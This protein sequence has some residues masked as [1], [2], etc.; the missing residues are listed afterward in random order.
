M[1]YGKVQPENAPKEPD[2]IFCISL[3]FIIDKKFNRFNKL[4]KKYLLEIVVKRKFLESFE[5]KTEK[6][7]FLKFLTS[8]KS[9]RLI[10]IEQTNRTTKGYYLIN[11]CLKKLVFEILQDYENNLLKVQNKRIKSVKS[12]N[13]TGIESK[14]IIIEEIKEL[15]KK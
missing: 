8:Q 15:L 12:K 4:Y 7:I 14:N 5:N 13:I 11:R 10:S 3:Y 6:K 1:I 9:K 2:I